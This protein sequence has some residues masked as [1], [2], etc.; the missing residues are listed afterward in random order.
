MAKKERSVYNN[1]F[2]RFLSD[3]EAQKLRLWKELKRNHHPDVPDFNEFMLMPF[4]EI[5]TR[6]DFNKK[7]PQNSVAYSAE[8]YWYEK[9]GIGKRKRI[10]RQKKNPSDNAMLFR[11]L[12]PNK[13][14]KAKKTKGKKKRNT[15]KFKRNKKR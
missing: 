9:L 12:E 7:F 14:H 6:Y 4:G 1:H 8:E 3:E 10:R 5:K 13:Q 2:N 15:Y 11:F